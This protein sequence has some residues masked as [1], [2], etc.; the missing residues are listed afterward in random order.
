MWPW[1][2]WVVKAFNDNLPYDQFTRWQLAGD[3]LPNS[4]H[5]QKLATAFNR[6]HMINGEGGRI[7]EENRVEYVMDMTETMGTIWLGMTLNCCRC[8][9]HKYD[10]ILNDEYYQL[11]AF[12]N[13]TSVNGGGNAQTPPV[14]ASPTDQQQATVSEL[15]KEKE[16]YDLKLAPEK[17]N[18]LSHRRHG[19]RQNSLRF[20]VSKHGSP[21]KS[22]CQSRE[23]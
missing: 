7:A 10:P 13:Q 17:N 11:F 3:L 15:Q 9:D 5:E 20:H 1:R 8:H 18:W 23:I 22:S 21:H 19:R 14:L 6:N 2:D 4:T 12:F 16:N